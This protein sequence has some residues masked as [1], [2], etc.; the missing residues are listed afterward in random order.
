MRPRYP[1]GRAGGDRCWGPRRSGVTDVTK[2]VL[3]LTWLAAACGILAPRETR[4]QP[5]TVPPALDL[6]APIPLDSAI[7][8]A[9]LANGLTVYVRPNGWPEDRVELRLA[10]RAGSVL[11]EDDQRGLAHFVEH[12]AFNG[13]EHFPPG[14]LVG[15]FE[16]LGARFGADLNASTSYDETVYRLTVPTEPESLVDRG[17]LVLADFAARTTFSDVEI[18][19]ER[20]VVLEEWRTRLGAGERL[21]RILDPV[22]Y[23]GSR[24]A[25]RHPIGLPE[26]IEKAPH[27]RLR[28]FYRT[29]YRADLMALFVVGDVDTARAWADVRRLF[30]TIP[31][32]A[33]GRDLPVHE[34][35]PH[36][37]TLYVVATDPEA[38]G[39]SVALV[40]KGPRPR[41]VTL[42]DMRRS[43]TRSLLFQMLNDRFR[44]LSRIPDAP[45]LAAAASIGGLGRKVRTFTVS[46]TVPDGGIGAGLRALVLET[47]RAHAY[48]F[49]AA[50]L[51]RA[52]Q[53]LLAN[54]E[55][56]ERERDRIESNAVVGRCVAHWLE[57]NPYPGVGD[58]LRLAQALLPA[59]AAT[60]VDSA[61]AA[62]VHDTNRVVQA[63]APEK[64]GLVP[65]TEVDLE[66]V[67]ASA[68]AE[69]VGAWLDKVAGRELLPEKP[70]PGAVR[71]RR[72]IPELG[73]TVL[74]FANGAEAWLKP[75]DFKKDQIFFVGDAP[76]G[77]SGVD[78]E[79]Y[80]L[81]MQATSVVRECGVG[82]LSPTE[83]TKL[84]AGKLA[85]ASTW[86]GP[87]SH[88]VSGS[89]SPE[90]LETAL[91]LLW[92]SFTEPSERPEGVEVVRKRLR[93]GL[94]NRERDPDQAF[95]D[96]LRVTNARHHYMAR[97]LAPEVADALGLD[98][99]LAFHRE[100]FANAAD[101]TFFVVGAFD[102][103]AIEPLLARYLGGLPSA[104]KRRSRARDRGYGFPKSGPV[105]V[106]VRRGQEPKSRTTLTFFAD[107]GTDPAAIGRVRAAADL[108]EM[109]L[110]D[111]LREDLGSTYSV[112]VGFSSL[113]PQVAYGTVS[114][115]FG[116]APENRDRMLE[117][118]R[119]E[120]ERLQ[121]EGPTDEDV[122]KVQEIARREL[123]V[124][125]KENQWWLWN[126]H[127]AHRMGWDPRTILAERSRIDA[128]D[129][130]T[131]QETFRRSFS[132]RRWTRV[133]L[134]PE[135]HPPAEEGSP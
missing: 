110:R 11:E 97:P 39:S 106:D 42:A 132:A 131:L 57:D 13:S 114:I 66:R 122:R 121:S 58:Q 126:L 44:E 124:S 6:A 117:A 26:V 2:I 46:A 104:G 7:S 68:A 27:E 40:H 113:R 101:F 77:A 70:A 16:S 51:E 28:D 65:P 116:S 128:L 33:A 69:S 23:H 14:T 83:I 30:G 63:V 1:R 50:E 112:S 24:Y 52:K 107:P 108:L 87:W 72:S 79:R 95:S 84:L 29:W 88:G 12:M 17:L 18:D 55:R 135:A 127:E 20:G 102:P 47:R 103:A 98:A 134:M 96:T 43:F 56:A 53:A 125:T 54:Y 94:A 45:F 119:R 8:I 111:I 59:I 74:R 36:D 73:V 61:F 120:I 100:R 115:S 49:G 64:P 129:A 38:R 71:E 86:I 105:E 82:G 78:P 123:E 22:R 80:Q 109:R 133:S 19:K 81:A 90:D 85:G 4:A 67:V 118:T 10:V 3:F 35:P 5:A 37:A 130:A 15:Y 91:Q 99:A 31:R 34:V 21:R 41:L 32:P 92:I 48:G 89:S 76:G 60:D 25:V 93:D 62:L 9:R 75:T